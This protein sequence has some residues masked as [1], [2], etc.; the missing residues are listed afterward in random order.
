M[1]IT[2]C[3]KTFDFDTTEVDLIG[4]N[5]PEFPMEIFKLKNLQHLYLQ[6]NKI[7]V[8]PKEIGSLTKLQ[9]LNLENNEIIGIPDEIGML[10]NL[11]YLNFSQNNI[12][13]VPTT[14]GMLQNLNDLYLDHNK[15]NNFTSNICDLR[16]LQ[17]L[18]LSSNQITNI[19][20]NIN[21][22]V[23]LQELFIHNNFITT[24]P[25]ELC[26]LQ[27]VDE[28]SI[29]NNIIRELPIEIV[30]L[31][32]LVYFGYRSNPI[33][34]LLNPLLQRFLQRFNTNTKY[35]H[36]IFNDSQNIHSSSIQQCTK[37]S[38][39]KLLQQLKNVYEYDYINDD[40]LTE[41]CKEALVEY[42]EDDSVH[43]QL[44]CNFKD[45]LMAVFY[46]ISNLTPDMQLLAKQRLNDEMLDSECKCFTGR[47]TRLVNSLSGISN[48][49]V[50]KI[51]DSEEIGN[52]ISVART[53]FEDVEEIKEYTM[54]ELKDRGYS[55]DI[56]KEWIEYIE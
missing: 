43:S 2:I 9:T 14:I 35:N 6:D 18:N 4:L 41:Q 8:I 50:I 33:D 1:S 17:I 32:N 28:L 13:F 46:E 44:E 22:L 37:D 52:I 3:N 55:D 48:K 27:N 36:N 23:N 56:I 49:V 53:K 24:I 47:I 12:S 10:T 20:N 39:Y 7:I 38:M 11:E 26:M 31:E 51:S 15:I 54:K 30:N 21:N 16:E 29:E 40:I 34:N 45:I 19:P 42:S 5:L 25:V